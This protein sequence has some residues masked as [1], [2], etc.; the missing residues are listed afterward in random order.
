MN[1]VIIILYIFFIPVYLLGQTTKEK[2]T[3]KK[4]IN[5]ILRTENKYIPSDIILD[6]YNL[7]IEI[8]HLQDYEVAHLEYKTSRSEA[9]FKQSFLIIYKKLNNE[10]LFRNIE[11]YNYK[12][13]LLDSVS[14]IFLSDNLVCES[15]FKCTSYIEINHIVNDT[16]KK[17][18]S[19]NGKNEYA[20]YDGQFTL[21]KIDNKDDVIGDTILNSF[22]VKDLEVVENS[23]ISF[24]LIQDIQ[25]L[26]DYNESE[27]LITKDEKYI[28]QIKLK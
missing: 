16:L 12:I 20:Y 5:D 25:I 19:F 24:T 8:F 4:V 1:R 15:G 13:E 9:S 21:D 2:L 26:I 7:P 11:P 10:L 17:I 3:K 6:I 18:A 23:L 27:G 14:S 28:K 22:T